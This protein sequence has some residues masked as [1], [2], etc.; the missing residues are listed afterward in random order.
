MLRRFH[1]T[2]AR[3]SYVEIEIEA[4]D[5]ACAA[6]LLEAALEEDH[7]LF[8]QGQPLGRPLHRIISAAGA[9]EA[10]SRPKAEAA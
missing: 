8:D 4:E 10:S 9:G 6:R 7:R 5:E 2:C 1:V 3:T